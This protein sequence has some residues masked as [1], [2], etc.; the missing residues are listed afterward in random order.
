MIMKRKPATVPAKAM[1]P[2]APVPAMAPTPIPATQPLH[3]P[4]AQG[5]GASLICTKGRFAGTAFPINGSLSIGRDP[6]RCQIVFP[7]DTKGISSLH[8]E[9]RW[10][11]GGVMLTDRGSSYGTF[12]TGGPRLNPGESVS[13]KSGDGFYLADRENI[14]EIE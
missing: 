10:Q 2:P 8:C 4:V 1:A 14:F 7:N 6:L 5:A 9:V 11:A 13:L 3:T 12:L